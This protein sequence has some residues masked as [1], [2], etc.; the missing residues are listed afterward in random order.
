MEIGD[1]LDA[2]NVQRVRDSF[3]RQGL[4]AHLGATL[5]EIRRGLV[6]IRLPYR[7][8][9]TQQHGY[10][11]AGGTSAIADS[12]GGYAGFTLF[13][14]DSSVL[15][16]EFKLNLL[17]PAEGEALEATG[18]VVKSGRTLTICTLEVAAL[19]AGQRIPVAIGQQ[20]LICLAGR[21]DGPLIA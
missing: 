19:R 1:E 7:A 21:P 8:E 5:T 13:P 14:P 15:T 9:L 17:N 6:V 12:A 3:D 18:R 10:F 11:H 16:V 4:M 20:T 2:A